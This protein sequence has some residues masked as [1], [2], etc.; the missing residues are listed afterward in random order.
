MPTAEGEYRDL[1]PDEV[2]NLKTANAPMSH[3]LGSHPGRGPGGRGGYIRSSDLNADIVAELY[4]RGLIY[5]DIPVGPDDRVSIPPLE[6]FVSNRTPTSSD[7]ADPLEAMLYSIFVA[8]SESLKVTWHAISISQSRVHVIDCTLDHQSFA[9]TRLLRIFENMR[10]LILDRYNMSLV[11]LSRTDALSWLMF[12][13]YQHKTS[14]GIH[15]S[16]SSHD[17][18]SDLAQILNAP[19]GEVQS[20]ISLALRLGFATLITSIPVG[21][22]SRQFAVTM[23]APDGKGGG[24][25]N[26]IDLDEGN[27][28]GYSIG[29][30]GLPST[31]IIGSTEIIPESSGGGGAG[32]IG[33]AVALLLDAEATSYLMMGALSPGVSSGGIHPLRTPLRD[34]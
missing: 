2:A 10:S 4:R 15:P 20:A 11:T 25:S 17:Q 18:V 16:P 30:G 6:G 26:L 1:S 29:G 24:N 14:S 28:G 19:L 31:S 7:T 8:S 34:R 21:L 5:F 22:D 12:F 9:F 23:V 13:N 27:D 3:A 33:R 32:E